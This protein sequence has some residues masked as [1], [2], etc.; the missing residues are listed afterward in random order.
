CGGGGTA[1][2]GNVAEVAD[3]G[4]ETEAPEVEVPCPPEERAALAEEVRRIADGIEPCLSVRIDYPSWSTHARVRVDPYCSDICHSRPDLISAQIDRAARAEQA[5]RDAV[6]PLESD[7]L[8][9]AEID[10]GG[11]ECRDMADLAAAAEAC[12]NVYGC[13]YGVDIVVDEGG[14]VV[15]V[16]ETG[17]GWCEDPSVIDC[18]RTVL[19]GL[20]FPCLAGY[21][22]CPEPPVVD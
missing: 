13:W 7:C 5:V 3:A 22:I 15:E 11:G 17:D 2:D 18:L 1:P 6:L 14:V 9:Y 12:S 19:V 21:E 4:D 10:A 16:R 8:R 20:E